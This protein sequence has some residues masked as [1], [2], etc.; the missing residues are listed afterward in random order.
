MLQVL[1]AVGRETHVSRA[2]IFENSA[3]NTRCSNT[4]E[5]C[6][7]GVTPEKENLQDVDLTGDFSDWFDR[8]DERASSTA[9]MWG[10]CLPPFGTS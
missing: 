5:W 6:R 7:E 8:F 9:R 1:E 3:D 4:F 10:P 2:Y